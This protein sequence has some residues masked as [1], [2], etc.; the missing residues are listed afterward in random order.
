M[1]QNVLKR[2]FAAGLA[3]LCI[4]ACAP[5]NI[6]GAGMFGGMTIKAVAGPPS[7]SS[8]D[9]NNCTVETNYTYTGEPVTLIITYNNNTLVQGAD[10]TVSGDLTG[11]GMC[12]VSIRGKGNYSGMMAIMINIKQTPIIL[13]YSVSLTGGANAQVSGSTSQTD[14]SGEMETV[15]YTANDGY[16]FPAF[17]DIESNGVTATRDS[18]TQVTVSGTPT[19]DVEITIPDAINT[20]LPD[21]K[22]AQGA[23]VDNVNYTR[24]VY[25]LPLSEL[26]GKKQ[27]KF[28]VTKGDASATFDTSYYYTG[29]VSSGVTYIPAN[30]TSVMLICNVKGGAPEELTCS[31][32]IDGEVYQPNN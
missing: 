18:A 28:T 23:V 7:G 24:F 19:A 27:A 25:V 9:I 21:D 22:Y 10:F 2:A 6:G 16:Q 11:P 3:V 12:S 4:A 30:E 8:I 17:A 29:M 20:K 5:A 14:V 32:S 1:K 26:N 13:S 15:T 31:L